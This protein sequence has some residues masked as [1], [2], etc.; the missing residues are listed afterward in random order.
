M[1]LYLVRMLPNLVRLVGSS[2]R[3][4]CVE[5]VSGEYA[6]ELKTLEVKPVRDYTEHNIDYETANLN[7]FH[8]YK[9]ITC[10]LI[11]SSR[12]SGNF[13]PRERILSPPSV[14]SCPWLIA[15]LRAHFSTM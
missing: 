15:S 6:Q 2:R 11:F 12:S 1:P 9:R 14:S 4:R 7:V 8:V 13:T 10:S 3:I 5:L